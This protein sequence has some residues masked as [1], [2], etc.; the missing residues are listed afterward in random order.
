MVSSPNQAGVTLLIVFGAHTNTLFITKVKIYVLIEWSYR[1]SQ[2]CRR[3][4]IGWLSCFEHVVQSFLPTYG[5]RSWS[6]TIPYIPLKCKCPSKKSSRIR[7]VFL[8]MLEVCGVVHSCEMVSNL[9]KSETKISGCAQCLSLFSIYHI[10]L[11]QHN[12]APFSISV[13]SNHATKPE[14]E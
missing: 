4:N 9:S 14:Q 13:E 7:D 11:Q 5:I 10:I 1:S 6:H 8:M 2:L 12:P 3:L